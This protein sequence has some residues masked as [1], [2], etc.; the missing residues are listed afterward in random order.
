MKFRGLGAF[1]RSSSFSDT[2][3]I[4]ELTQYAHGRSIKRRVMTTGMVTN[5]KEGR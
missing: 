1:R 5:M 4:V 2:G 3:G